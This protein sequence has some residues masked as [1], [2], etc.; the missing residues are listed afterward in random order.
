MIQ[1]LRDQVLVKP[2]DF[3][4]RSEG[5]ILLPVGMRQE[6]FKGTVVAVGPGTKDY[7]ITLKEGDFVHYGPFK[8]DEIM[9]DGES[10]LIMRE[11]D[12]FG[13]YDEEC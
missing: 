12:I 10:H 11:S 6:T 3:K 9:V 5:G 13:V 7:P 2:K 8:R 1:L 4:L